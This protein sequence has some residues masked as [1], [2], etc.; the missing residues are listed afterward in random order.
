MNNIALPRRRAEA[1]L[2]C[3]TFFW[4][5]T[6]PVV[7][8]VV[9]QLP[10]FAFLFLRFTLAALL[11]LAIMRRLPSWAACKR[12]GIIGLALFLIFAF[13]TWGLVYTSSANS[14]F[15]TGLNVVW[16]FFLGENNWR[17]ALGP[18]LL[19]LS[20]LW[21]LASPKF[22]QLNIGD[23]LT[24]ITSFCV[25]WHIL[26]LAKVKKTQNSADMALAQFIIVAALSLPLSIAF[27]PQLLPEQWTTEIIF[28]L[29]LTASG[30]TVFSFW[31]QTHYQRHTTA[32][33]AGLIFVC[34]PLFAA[35]FAIGLYGETMS[36]SALPGAGLM[37]AA[38]IWT[39]LRDKN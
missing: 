6:F 15:I 2:L 14:A 25:A 26:L 13:Q 8:D 21:L 19:A 35:G 38:M 16:I 9:A 37:L 30:A 20:G 32:L 3:A 33:R 27:E 10:V 24:L 23:V 39:I 12:S 29:L 4:G 1:M 22:S 7:K 17:R 11:M 5:W 31:A 18:V 34:E 28:G 36:L